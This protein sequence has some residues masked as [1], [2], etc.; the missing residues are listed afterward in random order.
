MDFFVSSAI[1]YTRESSSTF[2]ASIW[3]LALMVPNVT[4][5]MK[6]AREFLVTQMALPRRL[7]RHYSRRRERVCLVTDL[8]ME[9]PHVLLQILARREAEL[10]DGTVRGSAVKR[11]VV[12]VDMRIAAFG[13]LEAFVEIKTGYF[14]APKS[15]FA[16]EA[17]EIS[18]FFG[19]IGVRGGEVFY[20][21]PVASESF[22]QSL[23]ADII[24][25]F[26]AFVLMPVYVAPYEE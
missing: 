8:G 16:V 23:D 20:E 10:G 3:T 17:T 24:S 13:V 5:E 1:I 15:L 6:G 2:R 26:K 19:V 25:C 18:P 14:G 9:R 12:A 11:A 22:A 7:S 4:P 21:F